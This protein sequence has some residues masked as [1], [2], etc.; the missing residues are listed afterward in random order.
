MSGLAP[1]LR[2]IQ[3]TGGNRSKEIH[4]SAQGWISL[5]DFSWDPC[6]WFE[7]FGR[8]FLRFS[9]SRFV[10]RVV[11]RSAG[12]LLKTISRTRTGM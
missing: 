11:F 9:F 5:F 1:A 8:S 10:L 6:F 4:Q 2:S 7:F 12:I 3:G